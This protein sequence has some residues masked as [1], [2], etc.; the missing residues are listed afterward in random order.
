MFGLMRPEKSCAHKTSQDYRFHRMHYCGTCK[1]IG[2]IMDIGRE[3][4]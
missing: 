4:S 1:T 2:R 3:C